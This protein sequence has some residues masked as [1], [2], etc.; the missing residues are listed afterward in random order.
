MSNTQAD[1]FCE[2]STSGPVAP[3]K[4]EKQTPSKT[5]GSQVDTEV[6]QSVKKTKTE[7]KT[8]QQPSPKHVTNSLFINQKLANC[9]KFLND[10]K[11]LE[12]TSLLK[13]FMDL[14]YQEFIDW[15][16]WITQQQKSAPVAI[17]E[18]F[19]HHKLDVSKLPV[20]QFEKMQLYFQCFIDLVSY[21]YSKK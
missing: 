14:S 13:Q 11:Y 12:N 18:M 4:R 16:Y 21:D 19:E 10:V 3:K 7:E 8:E 5:S 6:Q 1:A 9:K 20:T 17:R 2:T 15:I